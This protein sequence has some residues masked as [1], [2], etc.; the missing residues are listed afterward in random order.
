MT[1]ESVSQWNVV[2]VGLWNGVTV[3]YVRRLMVW[4][5]HYETV[6]QCDSL[7]LWKF[8]IVTVLYCNNVTMLQCYRVRVWHCNMSDGVT[9]CRLNHDVTVWHVRQCDSVT[10]SQPD[11]LTVWQSKRFIFCLVQQCNIYLWWCSNWK[12]PIRQTLN[13][14]TDGDSITIAMKR[15]RPFLM[16]LY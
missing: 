11:S 4:Q 3:W 13:L 2:T 9:V 10:L 7:T 12:S 15:H 1:G 6:W 8:H 14:S 16:Q 5:W